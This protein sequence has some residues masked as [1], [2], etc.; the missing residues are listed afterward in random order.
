MVPVQAA[1]PV[2]RPV[3]LLLVFLVGCAAVAGAAALGVGA[4]WQEVHD[5]VTP[6]VAGDGA[7]GPGTG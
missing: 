2:R 5:W 4:V 3:L 1:R 7:G 6:Y